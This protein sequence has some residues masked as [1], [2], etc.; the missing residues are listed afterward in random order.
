MSDLHSQIKDLNKDGWRGIQKILFKRGTLK[1]LPFIFS[2]ILS[3]LFIS[4]LLIFDFPKLYDHLKVTSELI[5]SFFPNL[6]GFSLGGYALVVGFSNLELIKRATKVDGHS[7]YQILNAIFAL[8]IIF[9]VF[10]TL[11]KLPTRLYKSRR[12]SILQF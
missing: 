9:Q 7:I 4:F 3:L 11:L 8:C 10:T 1:K 12:C 5:L 2:L 6:L